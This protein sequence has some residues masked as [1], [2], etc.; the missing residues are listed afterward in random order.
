MTPRSGRVYKEYE[1]YVA[2][3]VALAIEYLEHPGRFPT[4]GDV[5][6]P[7]DYGDDVTE[8]TTREGISMP[9]KGNYGPSGQC[10][11]TTRAGHRCSMPAWGGG[12]CYMHVSQ[13]TEERPTN[14]RVVRCLH[15]DGRQ[16][17]QLVGDR[18]GDLRRAGFR[19][20]T[21]GWF[22]E[23]R[24][25]TQERFDREV[26]EATAMNVEAFFERFASDDD[27]PSSN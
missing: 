12:F 16:S 19:C 5:P 6:R 17:V 9:K 24:A 11:G 22:N 7:R 2:D 8:W 26:E 25:T 13:A 18:G 4:H 15:C 14:P 27:Q 10:H 20:T 1:E 21:C 3:R 23:F